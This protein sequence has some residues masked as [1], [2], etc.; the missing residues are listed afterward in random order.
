MLAG[1]RTPWGGRGP[2]Q[3]VV[4]LPSERTHSTAGGVDRGGEDHRPHRRHVVSVVLLGPVRGIRREY[5]HTV[6]I[7]ARRDPYAGAER[8]VIDAR[9]G[10]YDA[11]ETAV[12]HQAQACD[13]EITRDVGT[14]VHDVATRLLVTN[15]NAARLTGDGAVGVYSS[16]TRS[17]T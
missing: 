11:T 15:L 12:V 9:R 8:G 6:L 2:A 3:I 14:E 17:R 5:G 1:P 10:D 7:R 13:D 16:P 4:R